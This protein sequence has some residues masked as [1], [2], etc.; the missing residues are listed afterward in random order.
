MIGHVT[1]GQS[2][3]AILVD[4]AGRI[5]AHPDATRIGRDISGYPSYHAA[6]TSDQGWVVGNNASGEPTLFIF[7]ENSALH[8]RSGQSRCSS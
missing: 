8:R 4:D 7:Q 1:F 5:I 3:R 6:Q 2:G